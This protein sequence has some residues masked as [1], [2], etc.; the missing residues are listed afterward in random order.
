MVVVTH[1]P[2]TYK[3]INGAKKKKNF[4]SLYATDLEYLLKKEN[5]KLWICG[6][7]H[8]NI[9]FMTAND[10]RVVSNQKGKSKDHIKDYSK[11]FKISL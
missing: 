10:C 4:N 2:P 11:T 9:D 3:A 5:M 1:H 6:H 7:T 8:I